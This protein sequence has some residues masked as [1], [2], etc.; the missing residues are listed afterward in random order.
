MKPLAL[1]YCQ[2]SLGL[3]HFVRSLA[4]AEAMVEHFDLVF[5]NGGP[6]PEGLA[7][8]EGM[9]F[10]MLEPLRL[11][12]DGSI[13]GEGDTESI[14]GL[15]RERMLEIARTLKPSLLVVEL[16][17]FGRKKFAVELDPLI[18]QVRAGGGKVACS[19]RDVLV[20]ARLDQARH[21]ERAACKLNAG[22]D[23][24]LVHSDERL[25]R[26][27]DS[28]A[29]AS[30]LAIPIHHTGY[31]TRRAEAPSPPNP[32]GPT[33]VSAGGG[34]V[35]HAL[36]AAALEA[37]PRLYA[38]RGWKMTLVTGPMFPEADWNRLANA[39]QGVPGII[40]VRS[41]P[42]LSPLLRRAGRFAGQCGYNSALEVVQ[43]GIPALFVPFARGQESE[44]TARAG[45]LESLGLASS[46]PEADLTGAK[47][48]DALL[49]LEPPKATASLDTDGAANSAGL[50]RE[51]AA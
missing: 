1:L 40:A 5:L 22:F 48:A 20:N 2:H 17:P 47:L 34:A 14:L 39:A 43:A 11:Q 32:G 8:P 42:A 23:A 9:R 45:M 3:G 16:Y 29:P 13:A 25:F 19:V 26:L 30:P 46:L 33:L 49:G 4:L 51:L 50:L 7:L 38:E 18:A 35:G 44:Q 28:F 6:V 36:Y 15:R 37:Q 10:E 24:V 12:D 27:D 21:D 31:V 41:L